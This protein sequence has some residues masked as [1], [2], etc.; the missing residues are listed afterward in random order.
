MVK[1]RKKTPNP[2]VEKGHNNNNKKRLF[3]CQIQN[4]KKERKKVTIFRSCVVTMVLWD[5]QTSV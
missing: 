2:R 4:R 1:Q 5:T 3:P